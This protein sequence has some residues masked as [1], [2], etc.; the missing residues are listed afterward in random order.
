MDSVIRDFTALKELG[1]TCVSLHAPPGDGAPWITEFDRE[2][3]RV[4]FMVGEGHF[5]AFGTAPKEA[6]EALYLLKGLLKS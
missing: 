1:A 3:W 2:S 6:L 5:I 4:T